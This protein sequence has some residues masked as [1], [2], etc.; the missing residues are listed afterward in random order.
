MR[1]FNHKLFNSHKQGINKGVGNES[2]KFFRV[3]SN[4]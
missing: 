1:L 2:I 4:G 3:V